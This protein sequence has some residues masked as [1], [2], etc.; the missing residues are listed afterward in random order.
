MVISERGAARRVKNDGAHGNHEM[1]T[2]FQTALRVSSTEFSTGFIFENIFVSRSIAGV[3]STEFSSGTI[4]G[5][6]FLLSFFFTYTSSLFYFG[7]CFR[8]KFVDVET[9]HKFKVV[10]SLTPSMPSSKLFHLI[11]DRIWYTHIPKIL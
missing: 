4:I 8:V 10:I 2:K 3:L 9:V 5:E 1:W 11:H 7:F 6:N